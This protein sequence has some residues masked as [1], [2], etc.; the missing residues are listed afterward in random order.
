METGKLLGSAFL[1]VCLFEP[2]LRPEIFIVRFMM[3][4]RPPILNYIACSEMFRCSYIRY[5][6]HSTRSSPNAHP[7]T[8]ARAQYQAL[9]IWRP[10]ARRVRSPLPRPRALAPGRGLSIQATQSQVGEYARC[11]NGESGRTAGSGYE[12]AEIVDSS[13]HFGQ[14]FTHSPS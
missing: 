11:G 14:S 9:P 12:I 5:Y 13:P 2:L 6:S 7:M 10:V 4:R 1:W 8:A 3:T